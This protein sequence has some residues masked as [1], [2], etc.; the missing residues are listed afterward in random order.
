MKLVHTTIRIPKQAH[1]WLSARAKSEGLTT[2]E[3]IRIA[4][5]EYKR[6]KN[7]TR[8]RADALPRVRSKANG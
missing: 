5:L 4:L 8:E 6:G 3:L 1:D 2:S 7:G